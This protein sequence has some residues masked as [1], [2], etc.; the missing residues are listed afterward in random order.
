VTEGLAAAGEA[1]TNLVVAG[2]LRDLALVQGSPQRAWGYKQAAGAIL[3]L[4]AAIETLVQPDGTLERIPRI[5]PS[6]TRVIQEV[7]ATGGSPLVERAVDASG[8]RAEVDRR[9][10]LRAHYLSRA[11]VR[12]I[13]DDPSL[14]GPSLADYRGDLQMHSTWSDGSQTLE[15]IVEA[16]LTRGYAYAAVTDHS[17]GLPI[18]NGLSPARFAQQRVEIARVNRDLAGAGFRLLFGVEANIRADGSVDVE[19]EDRRAFD[20]VVAAPHAVLRSPVDQTARMV[21][22]VEAPAVHVLGHPRGRMFGSRP[23][24]SAH[25]RR[26]FEAA[27]ARGVAI[28]IDGDP[29]RQDVDYDMARAAL[30]AGCLFAVDT[31]AHA[32]SQ[33][34]YA[35]IALAHARLAGIPAGRIVNTWPL[36]RLQAWTSRLSAA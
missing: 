4:D 20:L 18:A 5:G 23:G 36:D 14:D 17:G 24:V 9:R 30:D 19:L 15:A 6:S 11:R 21:A 35:E 12:A 34:R 10:A 29:A 13:L 32:V 3:G 16:G 22:A 33:W 27:A 7:L 8:R 28:E 25:W 26:V 2:L 31:D 1:D